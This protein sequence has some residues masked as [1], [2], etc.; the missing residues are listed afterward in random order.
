MQHGRKEVVWDCSGRQGA[1]TSSPSFQVQIRLREETEERLKNNQKYLC[2]ILYLKGHIAT[3]IP[4][5]GVLEIRWC[6]LT[7]LQTHTLTASSHQ[8]GWGLPHRL[9]SCP[10][11][12]CWKKNVNICL[13]AENNIFAGLEVKH[14]LTH[15]KTPFIHWK[16]K[17]K[18]TNLVTLRWKECSPSSSLYVYPT[19]RTVSALIW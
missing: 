6:L 16:K 1:F 19:S 10:H 7:P 15:R 3:G 9:R 13:S 8:W 14:K 17:K 2:V 4:A 11:S 12:V 18:K 5:D